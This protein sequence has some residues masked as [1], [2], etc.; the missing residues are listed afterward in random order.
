MIDA[1]LPYEAFNAVDGDRS[2]DYDRD[3]ETAV[4]HAAALWSAYL[5]IPISETNVSQ[6]M[7]LMK[8]ARSKNGYKRDNYLDTIGYALLAE[9]A[10]RSKE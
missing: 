9:A 5:G 10:H 2:R 1:A 8:I 7:M 6:M 3:G 4:S